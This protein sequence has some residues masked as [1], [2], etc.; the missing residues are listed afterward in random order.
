MPGIFMKLIK[1]DIHAR[2]V[3]Q[4]SILKSRLSLQTPFLEGYR[5]R[6]KLGMKNRK[7]YS[8]L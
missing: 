7:P 5:Y 4:H 6:V 8:T 2:F 3:S 1:T